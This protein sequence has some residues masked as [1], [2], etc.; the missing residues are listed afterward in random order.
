MDF[1]AQF[2]AIAYAVSHS[3]APPVRFNPR[4]PGVIR[5]GSASDAVLQFLRSAPGFRNESQIIW[6]TKRSHSAVSWSLLYLQRQGLIE[7]MPE[8]HRNARYKRYRAKPQGA[9][10]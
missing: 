3:S 5:E 4:P 8:V 6:Q 1:L 7:A 2:Q 9:D 10:R